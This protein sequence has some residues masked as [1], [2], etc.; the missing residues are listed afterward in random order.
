MKNVWIWVVVAVVVIGG[1]YWYWQ[2]TQ[3]PAALSDD[4]TPVA[5]DVVDDSVGVASS[6]PVQPQGSSTST[7][8]TATVSYNGSSF[9]P[10]TVTIAE[11]GTVTFTSTAGNIWVASNP[12]PAHTGYD[13][14]T[15]QQHCAPGYTGAAPFDQCSAGTSFTFTFNKTGTWGYHN[16][17]NHGATGTVIVQ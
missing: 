6:T 8:M 17:L 9:S 3:A 7:P 14:S 4:G 1:G 2:S 12:H 5:A 11:G 16:H 13:G 10:S 15:L